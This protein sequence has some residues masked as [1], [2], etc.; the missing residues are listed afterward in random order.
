MFASCKLQH[1][2]CDVWQGGMKAVM[3]TDVFQIFIMFAG[4]IAILIKGSAELGG[5]DNVWKYMKDGE[6][7]QF[8]K[9][10]GKIIFT[11]RFYRYIK[12]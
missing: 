12:I 3:W 2:C 11:I 10:A 5:F 8:L 1:V 9:L 6:R 4:L 7:V